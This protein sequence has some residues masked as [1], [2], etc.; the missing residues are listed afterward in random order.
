MNEK[1][2]REG[3]SGSEHEGRMRT[4]EKLAMAKQ[5]SERSSYPGANVRM[6]AWELNTWD[7][8]VGFMDP[9]KKMD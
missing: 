8:H 5:A 7:G 3:K 2:M 9:T 6:P 1:M 4:H